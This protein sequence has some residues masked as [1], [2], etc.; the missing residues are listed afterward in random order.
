MAAEHISPEQLLPELKEI[1][2]L[3]DRAGDLL[4]LNTLGTIEVQ[5]VELP[6]HALILGNDDPNTPGIG[7]F[8]GIHGVER[9]GTEV[10]LAYMHSLIE[11]LS[12]SPALRD[13]VNQMHIVFMPMVNPGGIVKQTR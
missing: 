13:L 10:V 9:I 11:S 5:G 8:G 4:K 3:C 7:L 2:A 12:W 6:I 1:Q